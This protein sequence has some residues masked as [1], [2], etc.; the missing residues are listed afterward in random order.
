MINPRVVLGYSGPP[1][2]SSPSHPHSQACLLDKLEKNMAF[3]TIVCIEELD[4]MEKNL[5]PVSNA[6][7]ST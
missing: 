2:M 3:L 1:L 6:P 4:D 5:E 7:P